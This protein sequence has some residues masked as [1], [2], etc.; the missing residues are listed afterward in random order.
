MTH[1]NTSDRVLIIGAG[2]VGLGIAWK[3]AERGIQV[4]VLEAHEAGH[5][6]SSAAAGMLAAT[7]EV[8]FEEEALLELNHLSA[9]MYPEFVRQLEAASG[10]DVDYRTFGSLVVGLDR[11]DTEALQRLLMYQKSKQLP[12]ELLSGEQARE[13]EPALAPGVHSAVWC[14]DDHQVD[15]TRLVEALTVAFQRAGG[16]LREHAPVS[17]LLLEGGRCIGVEL[18][19][20][21]QLRAQRVVLATGAWTRKIQGIERRLLPRIRPVRG[22]MLALDMEDHPICERVIR[23]PDAYLVP[24]SSGELIIGATMEE[25]GFDGRQTAGGIFELLRGAW[26]TIPGVYDLPWLRSWTGFR[27]MSLRN[28]PVLGPSPEVEHLWFATGH[29]RNGILLAAATAE[30]MSTSLLEGALTGAIKEFIKN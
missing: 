27:P 23:A 16:E 5:G 29:G 8:N 2:V 22:Q 15:P 7:A 18:E 28:E 25:R 1:L 21:E 9:R 10:I 6:S 24:R 11:D 3:L 30:H 17:K 26:E 14:P 19:E 13:I 20:G 12:A 4:C